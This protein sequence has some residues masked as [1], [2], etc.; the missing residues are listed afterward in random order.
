MPIRVA[1]LDRLIAH[2]QLSGWVR[3]V[4]AQTREER[5]SLA[6]GILTNAFLP[7]AL[8][9]LAGG[10]LIWFGVRQALAPLASLEQ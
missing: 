3:I 9:V 7:I 4:V 5:E 8:A 6:R 1:V 2:P 10:G